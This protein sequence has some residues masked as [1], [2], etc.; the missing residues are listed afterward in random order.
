MTVEQGPA[1]APGASSEADRVARSQA[2]GGVP[3]LSFDGATPYDRYVRTDVLH[4]L[5]QPVTDVPEERAFLVAS[6]IMEL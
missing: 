6:Q 3:E 1:G 2:T 4:T 5:Q